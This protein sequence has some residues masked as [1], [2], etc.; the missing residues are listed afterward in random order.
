VIHRMR[1]EAEARA[2]M[3]G[4][5]GR[6]G[7]ARGGRFR[8]CAED[9]EKVIPSVLSVTTSLQAGAEEVVEARPAP[10]SLFISR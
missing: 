1:K 9:V 6:G 10:P 8:S 3:R 5:R 4:G 7:S 2:L